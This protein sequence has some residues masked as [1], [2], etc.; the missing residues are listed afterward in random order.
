[1][2]C[3]NCEQ[4]EHYYYDDAYDC[5]ACDIDLDEDEFVKFLQA[6]TNQCPYYRDDDE[7]RIVRKQ[8]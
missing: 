4:C 8:N 7:Y 1:M 5:Y 3:T 2:S 6:A